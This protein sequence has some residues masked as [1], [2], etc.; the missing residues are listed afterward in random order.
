MKSERPAAPII[1]FISHYTPP[2]TDSFGLVSV[3]ESY[4]YAVKQAGGLPV[5][6]ALVRAAGNE[7]D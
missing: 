4:M 5:I 2:K 1:G 7:S 6:Q 3:G